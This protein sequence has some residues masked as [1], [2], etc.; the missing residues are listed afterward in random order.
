MLKLYLNL[1]NVK[2]TYSN[3]YGEFS[4]NKQLLK[5]Y[6]LIIFLTEQ[7]TFLLNGQLRDGHTRCID[8]E[9]LG[10]YLLAF[11]RMAQQLEKG[12]LFPSVTLEPI[13][14]SHQLQ[15]LLSELQQIKLLK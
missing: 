7:I 14:G 3:A 10:R 13:E 12:I 9:I 15:Q 4:A 6:Y 2:M 8:D 1:S 5:Y 11:E